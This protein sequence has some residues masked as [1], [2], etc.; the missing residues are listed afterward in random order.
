MNQSKG[1][2]GKKASTEGQGNTFD[3]M[4]SMSIDIDD[5]GMEAKKYL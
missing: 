5:E 1:K 4:L 2:K 3:G